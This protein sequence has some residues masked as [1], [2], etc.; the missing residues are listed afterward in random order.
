MTTQPMPRS[1]SNDPGDDFRSDRRMV[2]DAPRL[3][4]G[5]VATA[6]VAG[7]VAWVGVLI[8]NDIL[9][10]QLSKAAVI[11]SVFGSFAGNYVFTAALLA[12]AGTGLA[13]ALCVSTPRPAAFFGWIVGLLTLVS[14]VI[15]FTRAGTMTDK[16]S[17]AVINLVIGLVVGSLIS[18]VMARTVVDRGTR[19]PPRR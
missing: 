11:L 15:P 10:F 18:A 17:V 1:G 3:W 19:V 9:D 7:L 6:V 13:H 16:V 4:A 5:G 2:V 12:L 14:V 8:G